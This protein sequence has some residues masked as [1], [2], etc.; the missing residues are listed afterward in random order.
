MATKVIKMA[1]A[2]LQLRAIRYECDKNQG[3]FDLP[4]LK[5]RV[6]VFINPGVPGAGL[7]AAYHTFIIQ[8]AAICVSYLLLLDC[9]YKVLLGRERAGEG[10]VGAITFDRVVT[11][12]EYLSDCGTAIFAAIG[13]SDP[14][15][16][17]CDRR[18]RYTHRYRS[19]YAK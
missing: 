14:D 9:V 7:Q 2:C 4:Q 16:I 13:G 1:T 8:P 11:A 17:I 15:P 19:I 6:W 3:R 12:R 5:K 18:I 10:S